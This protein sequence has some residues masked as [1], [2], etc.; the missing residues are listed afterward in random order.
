MDN[1]EETWRYSAKIHH[2]FPAYEAPVIVTVVH[3]EMCQPDVVHLAIN[4]RVVGAL[5]RETTDH[6]VVDDQK[7]TMVVNSGRDPTMAGTNPLKI[8]NRLVEQRDTLMAH[9]EELNEK[10]RIIE[11]QLNGD[12]PGWTS[13][14][15]SRFLV[16]MDEAQDMTDEDFKVIRREKSSSEINDEKLDEPL[17]EVEE[18]HMPKDEFVSERDWPRKL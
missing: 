16:F 7:P 15:S 10:I 1:N 14:K 4:N 18:E 17:H 5:T 3:D 11:Y 6:V 9:I 13:N 2:N 12:H 8:R